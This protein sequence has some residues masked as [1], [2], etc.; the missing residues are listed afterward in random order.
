MKAKFLISIGAAAVLAAGVGV[1]QDA[2]ELTSGCVDCH[3][4]AGQS[5]NPGIPI[6][7]GQSDIV[8]SDWI[9]AFQDEIR[10][11]DVE[12]PEG[13]SKTGAFN[14]CA[15]LADWDD[16][17]MMAVGEY[18]S[19]QTFMAADQSADAALVSAGQALHED[20]CEKCH[21]DAGA[22]ADDD[23]GLLAGQWIGYLDKTMVDYL[24]GDR[25]MPKKMAEKMEGLGAD[26]VAA[27]AHFY[28]SQG[29]N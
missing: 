29:G 26:D 28:G 16:D 23:A 19:E 24:N 22:N 11:C 4:E 25:D 10:P 17:A 21:T 5:P 14:H 8:V 12:Y 9:Y 15:E 20:R 13:A 6:L 18:Y 7:A 3:G 2:G 27:L 1:A